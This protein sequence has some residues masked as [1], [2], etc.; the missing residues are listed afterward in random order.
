[1]ISCL[2]SLGSFLVCE[3]PVGRLEKLI[4]VPSSKQHDDGKQL[5]VYSS[6]GS[7]QNGTM[8]G[9]AGYFASDYERSRPVA[10][11]SINDISRL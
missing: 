7:L 9:K 3:A 2:L 10:V 11:I 1:M 4:L 5:K 6:N 8:N